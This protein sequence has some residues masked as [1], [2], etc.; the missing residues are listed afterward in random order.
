MGKSDYFDLPQLPDTITAL[1][2]QI[3]GYMVTGAQLLH[4]FL[5]N[6]CMGV[7]ALLFKLI[8]AMNAAYLIYSLVMWVL[9]KIPMLNVRE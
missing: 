3:T 4:V 6:T 7:L 9:R 2:N 1:V 5:G 8:I